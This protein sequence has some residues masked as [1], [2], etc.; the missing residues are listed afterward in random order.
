M[1]FDKGGIVQH[2]SH[3][4]LVAD[5]KGKY[6]ELWNAQAQYYVNPGETSSGDGWNDFHDIV[7]P[8]DASSEETSSGDYWDDLHDILEQ[9]F[10]DSE[11]A[12]SGNG[13]NDF[14]GI[15][16]QYDGNLEKTL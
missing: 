7:K 15:E 1:V 2:G 16:T 8:Y 14:L 6:Y 10:M 9:Y 5:T 12:S 3:E 11:K 4:V 13:W